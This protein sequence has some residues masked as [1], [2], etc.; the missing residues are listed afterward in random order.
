MT[1]AFEFRSAT[2]NDVRALVWLYQRCARNI[3]EEPVL[4]D[5]KKLTDALRSP[6]YLFFVGEEGGKLR[7]SLSFLVDGEHRFAKLHRLYIDSE[8]DEKEAFD[9]AI[10]FAK[11]RLNSNSEVDVVY[12][13][14]R[15]LTLEQQEKTLSHG[16]AVLG[17][18][19]SG[20][21]IDTHRLNGMTAFY[22]DGVLERR[23]TGF[24]LHP[25]VAPYF[26]IV[27]KQ[28]NLPDL[29]KAAA[30]FTVEDSPEPL[31]PLEWIEAPLFVKR[32]FQDLKERRFLTN[33][34]YP[35]QEPNVLI[36]DPTQ[37]AEIF[38][39]VAPGD[40]FATVIGERINLRLNP[41]RL[42]EAVLSI[43]VRRNFSYIE[44][45]SDAAD[46]Q[47]IDCMMSAGFSPCAYIPAFKRH[48]RTRRDYVV[49]VHSLG[50]F[51]RAPAT[52]NPIYL[53]FLRH[54]TAQ[55]RC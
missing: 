22:S 33:H 53:D 28:L 1:K 31:P 50:R 37:N 5:A 11:E 52:I 29:P 6:Q 26:E 35:F 49:L 40:H 23:Q 32:K 34:F 46:T 42:Y 15:S 38:L 21:G 36:T 2:D 43:L 14:T 4:A 27:K 24:T 9:A 10:R 39:K 41:V 47:G 48:G 18:F 7:I 25:A 30:K 51:P 19:P 13:T 54:Y 17:I 45:V 55:T 3:L 8:A 16:F 12:S 20:P 44:I